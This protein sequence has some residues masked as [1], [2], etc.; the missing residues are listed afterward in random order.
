M[1]MLREML[2]TTAKFED[3]GLRLSRRSDLLALILGLVLAIGG[4]GNGSNS[5]QSGDTFLEK[6]RALVATEEPTETV[7]QAR[8]T[9]IRRDRYVA[10]ESADPTLVEGDTN[11]APDVFLYDVETKRKARVSVSSRGEQASGGSFAPKATPDGRIIVFES[12]ASNLVPDDTN[13]QRDIFVHD[14][15]ERT[16][17]RVSVNSAG[18]QANNFSQSAHVSEDGRF[19]AFESLASNL[20]AGDT[21]G[22]IDIFVYDRQ[23]KRMTRVSIASDGTPANNASV[24]PTISADGRYVTFDSFAT[25]LTP[26]KTDGPKQTYVHDRHTGNIRLVSSTGEYMAKLDSSPDGVEPDSTN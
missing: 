19:I 15:Q 7:N 10:F 6:V 17:S 3:R 22:V 8:S 2:Q 12:I 11:R 20:V 23:T 25:N 13:R 16:T 14:R 9:E 21:N 4:C 1:P 24:N 18:E 26:D 5:S